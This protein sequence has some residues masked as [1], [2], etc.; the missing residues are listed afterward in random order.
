MTPLLLTVVTRTP[1]AS[2]LVGARAWRGLRLVHRQASAVL[3]TAAS[4]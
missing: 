2:G 3:A 1:L 4:A